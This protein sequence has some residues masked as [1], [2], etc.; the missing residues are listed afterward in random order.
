MHCETSHI[1][2]VCFSGY[3][4]FMSCFRCPRSAQLRTGVHCCAATD[5]ALALTEDNVETVLDEVR[6]ISHCG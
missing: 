4:V 5:E 2:L 6:R 3:A 1:M